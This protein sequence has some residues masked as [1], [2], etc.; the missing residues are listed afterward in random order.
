MQMNKI[1]QSNLNWDWNVKR[2]NVWLK[3][4]TVLFKQDIKVWSWE[5]LFHYY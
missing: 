4:S 5:R 1:E 3:I 2:W